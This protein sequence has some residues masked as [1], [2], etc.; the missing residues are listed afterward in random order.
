MDLYIYIAISGLEE[1][2]CSYSPIIRLSLMIITMPI[3]LIANNSAGVK[4]LIYKA[5]GL[6]IK[7]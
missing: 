3:A 6:M 5:P 7:K 4:I 2:H 1:D